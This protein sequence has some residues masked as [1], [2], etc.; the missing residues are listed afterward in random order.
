[1]DHKF[2]LNDKEADL[3][4]EVISHSL[5]GIPMVFNADRRGFLINFKSSLER[6]RPGRR[7]YAAMIEQEPIVRLS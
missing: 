4:A 6:R 3:L 1:M 5:R 2:S 7:P